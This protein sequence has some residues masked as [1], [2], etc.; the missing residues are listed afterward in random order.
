MFGVFRILNTTYIRTKSMVKWSQ[1]MGHA[2]EVIVHRVVRL[3]HRLGRPI[4][5][6][7]ACLEVGYSLARMQNVF[8]MLTEEGTI[9]PMTLEEKVERKIDKRA[10][11]YVLIGPAHPSKADW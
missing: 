6:G 10:N 5:L 11:L 1:N 7:Q 9:R 4:Y 2:P 3:F 8:D